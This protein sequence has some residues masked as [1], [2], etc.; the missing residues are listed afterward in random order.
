MKDLNSSDGKQTHPSNKESAQNKRG[1]FVLQAQD[2]ETIK[3]ACG[4]DFLDD[5]ELFM[6]DYSRIRKISKTF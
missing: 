5:P 4:I 3:Q 1:I 6:E 2:S